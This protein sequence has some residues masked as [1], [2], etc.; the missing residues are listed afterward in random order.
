MQSYFLEQAAQATVASSVTGAAS[1]ALTEISSSPLSTAV[2]STPIAGSSAPTHPAATQSALST[3]AKAGDGL[4]GGAIAG[5]VIGCLLGLAIIVGA[6]VLCIMFNHRKT[7]KPIPTQRT[8]AYYS[9]APEVTD[10]KGPGP[11]SGYQANMPPELHG[12]MTRA[13]AELEGRQMAHMPVA[14]VAPM[15]E[16]DGR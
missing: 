8:A 9:G 12:S 10:K 13:D 14:M 4:R 15:S 3:G 7:K 16:L 5:V 11:M 6:L 1:S 2:A